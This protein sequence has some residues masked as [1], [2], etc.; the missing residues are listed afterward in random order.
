M[1][2]LGFSNSCSH[3]SVVTVV[4]IFTLNVRNSY[5][6]NSLNDYFDNLNYMYIGRSD[7]K[8]EN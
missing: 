8:E 5:F 3:K 6:K 4:G 2:F 1:C 7:K